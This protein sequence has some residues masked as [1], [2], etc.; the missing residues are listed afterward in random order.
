MCNIKLKERISAEDLE[1]D[2]KIVDY[3]KCL[4]GG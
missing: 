1:L 2:Y 4:Q 3:D